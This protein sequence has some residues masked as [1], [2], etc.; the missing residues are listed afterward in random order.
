MDNLG[1][2]FIIVGVAVLAIWAILMAIGS[3]VA[4]AGKEKKGKKAPKADHPPIPHAPAD[5]HAP[6]KDHGG[7]GHG[8]GHDEK[9]KKAGPLTWAIAILLLVGGLLWLTNW[10]R[11]NRNQMMPN[12]YLYYAPASAVPSD[13]PAPPPPNSI[14][15]KGEDQAAAIIEPDEP[16]VVRTVSGT[17]FWFTP[18]TDE[19]T[20][21]LC[22]YFNPDVCS[23][24]TE[25][26]TIPTSA[27]LVG[28]ASDSPVAF[29][30]EHRPPT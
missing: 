6:A 3:V 12:R 9:E 4:G 22:D 27:F 14:D 21:T 8:H 1:L 20:I 24:A 2:I 5:T 30:C 13:R 18:G 28:N 17:R 25:T 15:C 10:D 29:Y 26:R 19:G 23:S 7:H 11:E 16:V